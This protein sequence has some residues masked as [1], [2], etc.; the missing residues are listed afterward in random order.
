MATVEDSARPRLSRHTRM[1]FD[2]ARG[3]YALLSPEAVWVL[4][5]TGA[6]IAELCDGS[7]TIA[8]IQTALRSRYDQ[9]TDA[10]IRQFVAD[11]VAH[12]HMEVDHG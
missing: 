12:H 4:N 10:D 6:A 9:V 8:E 7:R 11:L 5:D 2:G 1:R 3:Q